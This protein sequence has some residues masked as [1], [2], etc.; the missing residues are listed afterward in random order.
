MRRNERR[1]QLGRWAASFIHCHANGTRAADSVSR[2]LRPT[3]AA[4]VATR[5]DA[6]LIFGI[7]F[8]KR[9]EVFRLH[10]FSQIG[11]K[12]TENLLCDTSI[13]AEKFRMWP[14]WGRCA[15]VFA[16]LP[17]NRTSERASEGAGDLPLA[18][19][20]S[21]PQIYERRWR[22]RAEGKKGGREAGSGQ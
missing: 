19:G 14:K 8:P 7:P 21:L 5:E 13:C 9:V 11:P 15:L 1:V 12:K 10:K 2:P 22:V 6:K 20:V 3:S 17:I 4:T 16:L 18:R